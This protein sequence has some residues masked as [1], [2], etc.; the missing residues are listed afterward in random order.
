MTD[1]DFDNTADFDPSDISSILKEID[2]AHLA[3]DAVDQRA[4]KLKANIMSLLQAQS[5]PNP[6]ANTAAESL[7][8]D[9]EGEDTIAT[10]APTSHTSTTSVLSSLSA[11]D[12]DSTSI[13]RAPPNSTVNH[14]PSEST[15]V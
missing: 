14:S 9:I 1:P 2:S 3:L 8:S 6:Y 5:Q 11:S 13:P 10:A 4:D 15:T 7:E 12:T